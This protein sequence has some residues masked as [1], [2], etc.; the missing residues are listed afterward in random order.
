MNFIEE[1]NKFLKECQETRIKSGFDNLDNITSGLKEGSL[2]ILAGIASSGKTTFCYQLVNNITQE[3][4]QKNQGILFFNLE[5]SGK[6]L[7]SKLLSN[8]TN[9]DNKIITNGTVT[10]EIFEKISQKCKALSTQNIYIDDTVQTISEIIEKIKISLTENNTK[11]VFIDSFQLGL[12]NANRESYISDMI[13]ALKFLAMDHK[14]VIIITSHL[15]RKINYREDKTPILSD[16]KDSGSLE[17]TADLVLLLDNNYKK[18][19]VSPMTKRNKLIVAKN[20]Y[21]MTGFT[22]LDFQFNI[23]RVTGSE[24]YFID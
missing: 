21:G 23:P 18:E 10:P 4:Q 15:S 17:E 24:E 12:Q 13:I 1:A 20:R 8:L 7:T 11:V 9:I 6:L 14:I 16:L 2:I 19:E 22:Y 3:L 5:S